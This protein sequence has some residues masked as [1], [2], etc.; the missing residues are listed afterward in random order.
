MFK[1]LFGLICLNLFVFIGCAT[2]TLVKKTDP[3]SGGDVVELKNNQLNTPGLGD[4][5]F[6]AEAVKTTQGTKI[7]II[8]ILDYE[9]QIKHHTIDVTKEYVVIADGIR[10]PLKPIV[11]SY[12]TTTKTGMFAPKQ[13]A[14]MKYEI[15]SKS[16]KSIA[17]AKNVSMKIFTANSNVDGFTG[18]FEKRNFD[19]LNEFINSLGI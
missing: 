16:L 10:I 6:D 17:S 11:N 3:F 19:K 8:G 9:S 1:K 5:Y 18:T 15:S 7:E 4:I 12:V 13:V 2:P 14:Q